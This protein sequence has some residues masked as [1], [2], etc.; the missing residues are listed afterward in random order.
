MILSYSVTNFAARLKT[1]DVAWTCLAFALTVPNLSAQSS[2]PTQPKLTPLPH[3]DL[4]KP[5]LTDPGLPLWLVIV[6]ALVALLLIAVVVWLLLHRGHTPMQP[7]A[8]PLARARKRLRALLAE[9]HTLPPDEVGHQVSV[10]VRDYQEARY[11]VPAP[12]RTREEL[13][14]KNTMPHHEKLQARFE[15]LAEL[16]DRLAFAPAPST[17]AQAEALIQSALDALDQESKP[18][19][20]SAVI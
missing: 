14:E 4:P 7:P 9:C 8:L 20:I 12:Y 16:C 1:R 2:P 3:P 6:G 5:I 10:I 17:T 19:N 18:A 13:Y 11:A 15:P